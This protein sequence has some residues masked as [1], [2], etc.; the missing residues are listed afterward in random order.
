MGLRPSGKKSTI[1]VD[2]SHSL[3]VGTQYAD[4]DFALTLD[5]SQDALFNAL[6]KATLEA[7]R[8]LNKADNPDLYNGIVN[9]YVDSKYRI[10]CGIKDWAGFEDYDGNELECSEENVIERVG[11]IGYEEFFQIIRKIMVEGNAPTKEEVALDEGLE[12]S[13]NTSGGTTA[14]ET[15][16]LG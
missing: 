6:I 11:D 1:E 2:S 4:S 12:S 8:R 9:A 5:I 7:N 13:E 15:E 3:F 10:I 14:Q 16:E